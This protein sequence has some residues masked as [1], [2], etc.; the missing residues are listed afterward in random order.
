MDKHNSNK[1]HA[2]SFLPNSPL[3]L[4]ESFLRRKSDTEDRLLLL[5]PS[6]SAPAFTTS[7]CADSSG[8]GRDPRASAVVY[9]CEGAVVGNF[10]PWRRRTD[11]WLRGCHA[12]ISSTLPLVG[13]PSPSF[14]PAVGW[15]PKLRNTPS[16]RMLSTSCIQTHTQQQ[17]N[18]HTTTNK[19]T[20]TTN[21]KQTNK[22][23]GDDNNTHE[24]VH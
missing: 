1:T 17:T 22:E 3:P 24:V 11:V 16:V 6:P 9:R 18:T 19:H 8:G 15:L 10:P 14:R 4:R 20:H 7:V 21:N 2:P 23:E 12:S 13:S 5:F